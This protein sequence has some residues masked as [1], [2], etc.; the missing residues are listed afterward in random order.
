MKYQHFLLAGVA[1][2]AA[3]VLVFFLGSGG[4]PEDKNFVYFGPVIRVDAEKFRLQYALDR[5]KADAAYNNK[6]VELTGEVWAIDTEVIALTDSKHV[7][8]FFPLKEVDRIQKEI[9]ELDTVT[10]RGLCVGKDPR[11]PAIRI[12]GCQLVHHQR[13]D[14]P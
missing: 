8:C 12:K 7:V 13:G 10:I 4:D 5:E 9:R 14:P 11:M 3:A 1:V 2:I 6:G